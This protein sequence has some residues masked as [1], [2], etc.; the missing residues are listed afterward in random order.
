LTIGLIAKLPV[1]QGHAAIEQQ[2]ALARGW[3]RLRQALRDFISLRRIGP[4]TARLVTEEED[5]LRR[6]N[7]EIPSGRIESSQREFTVVS[8]T[9]LQREQDF[10]QVVVRTV[11]G[12]AVRIKDVADVQGARSNQLIGYGLVVGSNWTPALG[13]LLMGLSVAERW[14]FFTGGSGANAESRDGGVS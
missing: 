12:Y 6:Q 1:G 11:N 5:A 3:Q 2:G 14:Q 9:D 13:L 4:A 10:E 8:Q 7:V